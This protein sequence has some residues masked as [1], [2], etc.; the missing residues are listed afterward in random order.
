L[1]VGTGADAADRLAVSDNGSTL[2]ADSAA[3]TGLSYKEDYAAGKNAIINADFSINQRAFTSASTSPSPSTTSTYG[4]DRFFLSAN[5]GTSTYSAE[6]FTL[7]S[8]P[9]AGYEAKNYARIVST[10]QTSSN[11]LTAI[12]QSIESVRT[13]AGETI[14]VS[15]WAQSGSGTPNLAVWAAQSFGTGGSPSTAVNTGTTKQAISTSWTR[16]SFNL[17]IPS[18]SG[19]TLGTNN[20]DCLVIRITTSAGT[21]RNSYT[22]SLGIQSTTVNIWG[23]QVEAGS[24]ATAFQ[25]ATGTLQGEL[26]ACQRYYYLHAESTSQ[27]I[28]IGTYYNGSTLLTLMQLPVTMRTTPTVENVSGTNYYQVVR[29]DGTDDFNSF[30]SLSRA[31]NKALTLDCTSNISGTAGQAG[32]VMTN[33]ASAKLAF[34]AEL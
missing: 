23:V 27:S 34:T 13:F 10:G 22:N 9:V 21:N 17:S 12:A 11:A 29:N 7:G 19:K 24:V 33:N 25:T 15:F 8:A 3:T 4:F 26:A 32:I 31:S 14:T 5:D 20:D 18:I 6:T 1:I 30:T 28:G 2:V 16:Y